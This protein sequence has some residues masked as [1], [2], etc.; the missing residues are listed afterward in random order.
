[1]PMFCAVPPGSAGLWPVLAV[2]A[3]SGASNSVCN[4]VLPAILADVIDYERWRSGHGRAG[5]YFAIFA[6]VTKF[7]NA[8]GGGLGL[9]LIGAFGYMAG[10]RLT[11]SAMAGLLIAFAGVPSLLQLTAAVM[12]WRFPLNER[13]H[14]IVRRRLEGRPR[15]AVT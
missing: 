5:G 15:P 14:D 2:S 10:A 7:N 6:L 12:A 11:E 8:V 3:L 1:M 13:R 9:L 4:V